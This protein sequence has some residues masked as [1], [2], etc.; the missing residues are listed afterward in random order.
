M[1]S[2]KWLKIMKIKI[3]FENIRTLPGAEI[4]LDYP[5]VQVKECVIKAMR[6]V[7]EKQ[8]INNAGS[9]AMRLLWQIFEEAEYSEIDEDK[10]KDINSID[11]GI[12]E[13]VFKGA[14]PVFLSRYPGVMVLDS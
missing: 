1:F 6:K 11:D 12:W 14:F 3:D 2:L 8:P 4:E 10:L 5:S 9:F 7:T 13:S